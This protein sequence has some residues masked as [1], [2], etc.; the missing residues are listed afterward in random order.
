MAITAAGTGAAAIITD[1]T[2][3][4]VITNGATIVATTTGELT[5][6]FAFAIPLP[7]RYANCSGTNGSRP[8]GAAGS[9]D[10]ETESDQPNPISTAIRIRSE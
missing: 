4:A 7:G 8:H 9:A 10:I 6:Q 2:G 3:A 5:L 1:G